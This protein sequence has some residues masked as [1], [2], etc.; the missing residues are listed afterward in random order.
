[1]D[2]QPHK[3]TFSLCELSQKFL[4]LIRDEKSII[5]S[6]TQKLF[7]LILS[8][9]LIIPYIYN[10]KKIT[11]IFILSY[12]INYSLIFKHHPPSPMIN[13]SQRQSDISIYTQSES[14]YFNGF[15]PSIIKN[16]Y[17]LEHQKSIEYPLNLDEHLKFSKNQN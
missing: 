2:Y 7:L 5:T 4:L 12:N 6:H 1:M 10:I 11:Y 16:H 8:M 3:F 9:I 14:W 15:S 13:Y 17:L